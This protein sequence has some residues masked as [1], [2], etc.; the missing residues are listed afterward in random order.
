MFMD[1][2]GSDNMMRMQFDHNLV[3][4]R[5]FFSTKHQY[6]FEMRW[7][8]RWTIELKNQMCGCDVITP[9]WSPKKTDEDYVPPTIEA[10]LKL[11]VQSLR[12]ASEMENLLGKTPNEGTPLRIQSLDLGEAFSRVTDSVQTMN[13][14]AAKDSHLD[15][16]AHSDQDTKDDAGVKLD[17][18]KEQ[19]HSP[20][21][22]HDEE[23]GAEVKLDKGEQRAHSPESHHD[24]EDGAVV[25]LDKGNER[26]HTPEIEFNDNELADRLGVWYLDGPERGT[27]WDGT[28]LEDDDESVDTSWYPA[29]F[30][31]EYGKSTRLRTNLLWVNG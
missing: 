26:A 9:A 23:N 24:D 27:K 13:I 11:V 16:D 7:L 17:K 25:K 2:I 18:G 15:D 3:V 1:A 28:F 5:K 30:L 19:A 20:E 29:S 10:Q 14:A 6:S 21:S 4:A 22:Q 31:D 12:E 8:A